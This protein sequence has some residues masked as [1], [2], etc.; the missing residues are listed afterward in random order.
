[1]VEFKF[2]FRV[3]FFVR[4]SDLWK[5]NSS[6]LLKF[7]QWKIILDDKPANLFRSFFELNVFK[8]RT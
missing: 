2:L 8:I 7:F 6:L 5:V 4:I 1:M 3:F